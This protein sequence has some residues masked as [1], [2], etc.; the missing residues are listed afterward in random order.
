[1]SYLQGADWLHLDVMDGHFVPN[2]SFGHPVVDSLRQSLGTQP[3]FDV[4]LMV[5]EPEKWMKPMAAAGWF[6]IVLLSFFIVIYS[7]Q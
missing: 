1:M 5:S 6:C 4:H 3:I 2:L 7:I